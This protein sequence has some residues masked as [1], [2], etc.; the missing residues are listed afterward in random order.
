MKGFH[1]VFLWLALCASATVL[2]VFLKK[3]EL[4]MTQGSGDYLLI[5]LPKV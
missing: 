1:G 3:Q 5:V 4:N 2:L